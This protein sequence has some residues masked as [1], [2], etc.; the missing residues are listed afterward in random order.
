MI[1]KE[2][3][4]RKIFENICEFKRIFK[5]VGVHEF[6]ALLPLASLRI[7]NTLRINCILREVLRINCT[8]GEVPYRHP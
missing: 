1:P 6:C 3:I 7:G 8:L 4:S 2:S 5:I